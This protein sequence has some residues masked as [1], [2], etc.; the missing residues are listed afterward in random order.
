MRA[1][2][3][4]ALAL[5]ACAAPP[6]ETAPPTY[7]GDVAPILA[8]RC[9][10]CHTDGGLGPF[11]LESY[12]QAAEVAGDIAWVTGR[13][14][15]PPWPADS[16]GA[17]G[18]YAGARWLDD[19]E[20]D[21]LARWAAAGAPEGEPAVAAPVPRPPAQPFRADAR[22][23]ADAPHTVAPGADEYRCFPVDLGLERDRYYTA[24]SV[25]LDRADVVHHIQLYAAQNARDEDDLAARDSSDPAP[26]Y[27]CGPEGPGPLRYIG[28]WAPGDLV[29]RWADDTGILLEAG[30]T[31]VMQVHYHNHGDTPVA[32]RTAL[33]LELADEVAEVGRIISFAGLPLELPPG[34]PDVV[35]TGGRSISVTEPTFVR[36]VRLHMHRLGTRGRL[37]LGRDLGGVEF[38]TCL[39][40]I[41]RWDFDWQLFY[42]LAEPI[43]LEHGDRIHVT[44]AYDTRSRDA[45]TVWGLGTEDEMCLG[46]T[47]LTSPPD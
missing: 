37:E 47:Y 32:D 24:I 39:L 8:A 30:R 12:H 25:A 42:Q 36:G 11:P 27:A 46:Y 16:S 6:E 14:I 7:H 41:P 17:C 2:L 38:G 10:T 26:G 43:P 28:V 1:R 23:Q 20:I 29:R 35:V 40:D 9:A 22:L 45:T 19:D 4:I 44:C 18:T 21:T 13:R 34:Q 33:D 15:M 31:V 3:G 5:A